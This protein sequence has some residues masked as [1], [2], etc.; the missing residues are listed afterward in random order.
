MERVFEFI[1]GGKSTVTI[2]DEVI[3]I[4]RKG[5]FNNL[6]GLKGEKAIKLDSISGVQFK[7]PGIRAGYIQFTIPGGKERK[8][9]HKAVEDENAVLFSKKE[10]HMANEIKQIVE[11]YISNKNNNKIPPSDSAADEIR[12]LADLRDSGI[13]TDEEFDKKKKQLLGI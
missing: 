3:R 12:K 10:L 6:S 9:V 11:N 5:L 13:L 7:E 8:G 2:D 1:H 4:K